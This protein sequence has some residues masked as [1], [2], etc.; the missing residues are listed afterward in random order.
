MMETLVV[1]GLILDA[2]FAGDPL[3]SSQKNTMKVF[4]EHNIDN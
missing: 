4:L 2:K 3:E 1:E